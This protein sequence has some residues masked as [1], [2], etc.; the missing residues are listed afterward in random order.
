MKR[1]FSCPIFPIQ[2]F[3]VIVMTFIWIYTPG[4]QL[5]E[6]R[7]K[8]QRAASNHITSLHEGIDASVHS[9]TVDWEKVVA[10]GYS[11]AFVKATEGIDLEDPSFHK[12]WQE[13][14]KAGIIRGAYHFYVTEDNPKE[15]AKFF[16]DTV[17]LKPGDLA[18]VV[19]VEIIGH[20]TQP[21]LTNRVKILLELIEK[22]Y[23]VKPIIYT[24]A[25]FW[26]KHLTDEFGEYPL[27]VAEYQVDRPTL[28]QGWNV[29]HL[30]Q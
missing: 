4:L 26:N 3:T 23:G 25:R 29:W 19:D 28:P 2:R 5:I 24:T 9:G 17:T 21:G 12:H 15:Q 13:M 22:H 6:A 11:F 10:N 7:A 30:W 27:W 1:T 20:N 14:K 18:P 8:E 16:I